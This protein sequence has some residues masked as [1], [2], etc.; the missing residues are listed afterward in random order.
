[1]STDMIDY[2]GLVE[3]FCLKYDF[4][5]GD[6]GE[7]HIA[8]IWE[9]LNS[10]M[11]ELARELFVESLSG[12]LR[13][14]DRKNLTKE[15]ND[16]LFLCFKLAVALGLNVE[17]AFERVAKSNLTKGNKDGTYIKVKGK[18]QKGDAY[19]AP[20]LSDLV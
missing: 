3:E 20:D 6:A 14:Q 16:V 15:L 10:E 4:P 13:E 17:E 8:S 5:V 18:L 11:D 19:V 12:K 2:Y 9:G 7:A 1:M